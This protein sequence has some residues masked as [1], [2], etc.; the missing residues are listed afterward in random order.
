MLESSSKRRLDQERSP[1]IAYWGGWGGGAK[2]KM[3]CPILFS[4]PQPH[5]PPLPPLFISLR[6]RWLV[7]IISHITNSKVTITDSS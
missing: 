1:F 6:R 5:S 7:K 2:K 3:E 4:A